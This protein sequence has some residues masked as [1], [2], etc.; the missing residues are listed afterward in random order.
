VVPDHEDQQP[1]L[2]LARLP[3]RHFQHAGTLASS[4]V[5]MYAAARIIND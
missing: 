4:V 3:V 5:V 2:P 1:V